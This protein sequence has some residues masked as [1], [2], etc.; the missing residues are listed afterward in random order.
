MQL[1]GGD[2]HEEI[3]AYNE[4]IDLFNAKYTDDDKDANLWTTIKFWTTVEDPME[5]WKFAC[6]GMMVLRPGTPFHCWL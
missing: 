5:R 3:M 1:G 6:C 2:G 4:L